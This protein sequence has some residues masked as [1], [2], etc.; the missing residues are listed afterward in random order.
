[1]GCVDELRFLN[2]TLRARL[3]DLERTGLVIDVA[4]GAFERREP[5]GVDARPNDQVAV[6][7]GLALIAIVVPGHLARNLPE[8]ASE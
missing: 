4:N 2:G 8:E 1:M 5:V 3:P 7:V 6:P